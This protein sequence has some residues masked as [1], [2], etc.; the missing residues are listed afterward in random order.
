MFLEVLCEDEDVIQVD[1]DLPF[2]DELSECY[3]N[4]LFCLFYLILSLVFLFILSYYIAFIL[5]DHVTFC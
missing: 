3:D 5:L 4:T 1:D 2:I